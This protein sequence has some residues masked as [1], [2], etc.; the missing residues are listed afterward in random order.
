MVYHQPRPHIP[1]QLAETLPRKEERVDAKRKIGYST[2]ANVVLA[3]FK[4]FFGGVV[5]DRWRLSCIAI[6]RGCGLHRWNLT[7]GLA[8]CS[9]MNVTRFFTSER[10]EWDEERG[11]GGAT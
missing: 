7:R 10:E 3:F 1:L 6:Q 2:S 8:R 4:T 11:R 9:R 5:S